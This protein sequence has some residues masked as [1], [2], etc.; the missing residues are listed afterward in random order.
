MLSVWCER[1]TTKFYSI[2]I[3]KWL[4]TVFANW[5]TDCIG[6]LLSLLPGVILFWLIVALMTWPSSRQTLPWHRVPATITGPPHLSECSCSGI[7]RLLTVLWLKLFTNLLLFNHY[8]YT[9][10]LILSWQYYH[11]YLLL[12]LH[13]T[14]LLFF[15]WNNQRTI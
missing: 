14:Y 5:F 2:S 6:L 11:T 15:F 8:F 1:I 4:P 9:I 7:F 13:S 10:D 12:Q 3:A